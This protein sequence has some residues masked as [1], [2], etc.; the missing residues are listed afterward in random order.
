MITPRMRQKRDKTPGHQEDYI[1][2]LLS[3]I[4]TLEQAV[5][6]MCDQNEGVVQGS[7]SSNKRTSS[8]D[9]QIDKLTEIIKLKDLQ[10]KEIQ[11]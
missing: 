6:A 7:L 1:K 8:K 3:R 4:A 5:Y 9:V 2:T 11:V 10:I